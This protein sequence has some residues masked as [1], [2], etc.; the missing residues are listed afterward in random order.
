MLKIKLFTVF[1]FLKS[2]VCPC[3]KDERIN[4]Y[5]EKRGNKGVKISR[6]SRLPKV[7]NESSGLLM[8]DSTSFWT[9]NDGGGKAEIYRVSIEGKLLETVKIPDARNRDWEAITNDKNGNIYIGDFG[10][11]ANKRKDLVIYKYNPNAETTEKIN[12]HYPD[13]YEFPPVRENMNFDAEAFFWF[14]GDLY[15]F[16]KNR[17]KKMVKMYQLPDKPGNY[18][19]ELKDSLFISSMITDAALSPDHSKFVLLSYGQLFEFKIEKE[20]NFSRPYKCTRFARSGQSEGITYLSS[21][22]LL[23]SNENRKVFIKEMR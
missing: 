16:S 9:F 14:D 23:L 20:V 5:T 6:V 11:N 2:M 15:V 13:Q 4:E 18:M 17:G 8:A 3:G 19:A 22:I 7:I 21:N 10:N 12:F 1:I